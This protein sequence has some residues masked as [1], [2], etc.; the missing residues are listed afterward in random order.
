M[1]GHGHV[2]NDQHNHDNSIRPS[3]KTYP[4]STISNECV[5]GVRKASRARILNL[6]TINKARANGISNSPKDFD[7][8]PILA[9]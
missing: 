7:L 5:R 9:L 4:K 1:G 6:E 8:I 2:L 3:K